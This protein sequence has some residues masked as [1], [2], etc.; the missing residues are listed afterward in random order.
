M[1]QIKVG[2]TKLSRFFKRPVANFD[3]NEIAP[4]ML[5]TKARLIRFYKTENPLSTNLL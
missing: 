5:I 3:V 1:L 4:G 2:R